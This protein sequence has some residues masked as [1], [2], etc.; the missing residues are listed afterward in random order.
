MVGQPL[1]WDSGEFVRVAGA[2][3]TD[4]DVRPLHPIAFEIGDAGDQLVTAM[5]EQRAIEISGGELHLG[6]GAG[7][8][9]VLVDGKGERKGLLLHHGNEETIADLDARRV[10]DQDLAK[11]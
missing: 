3:Q 9:R 5:H 8:Y 2:T 4:V 1:G 7:S 10:V 11:L 6:K